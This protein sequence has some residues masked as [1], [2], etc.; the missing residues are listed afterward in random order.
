IVGLA[1][2]L[3]FGHK[4]RPLGIAGLLAGV[5]GVVLIMGARLQGGVDLFGVA[6]CG[7]G[8]VSLAVATMALRNAASGGNFLMVVGL[9]MLVGSAVLAVPA[10]M[11]E[12]AQ[13]DWSWR[14]VGAF[15]YTM[16]VPGL[17]ATLVWF[18]LVD[19]IGA[20]K[21]ATFH[22]L[23]PFFGVAVAAVIL[24]ETL[25]ALDLVGVAVITV[26]ILAVQIARQPD[27]KG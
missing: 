8:V 15:V 11:T 20:L 13:V 17:A 4:L 14:L 18:L 25:G 12:T 10:W 26:G 24:G 27:P 1:G 21:A 3:L 9:Q 23:N 16:L 2:W 19:R 22:F 7:V 6:L 5:L